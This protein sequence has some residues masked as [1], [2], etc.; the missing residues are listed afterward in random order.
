MVVHHENTSYFVGQDGNADRYFKLM[1]NP[2][3]FFTNMSLL[4]KQ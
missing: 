4:C 1:E 2:A 3:V